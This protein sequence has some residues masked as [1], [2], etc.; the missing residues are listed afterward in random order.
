LPYNL[1]M[2]AV[3]VAVVLLLRRRRG[4][5]DW[6]VA[7]GGAGAAACGLGLVLGVVFENPFGVLRLW[8]YGI[9]FHGTLLLLATA[10]LCRRRPWLAAG[11]ALAAAGLVAVAADA[12][13]VE[14][15]RLEISHRR[16]ASRKIHKP[17][18]IVVVADLQTDC[19]GPFERNVLRQVVDEKPDVI[20]F[21]G[22]Y[23]ESSWEEQAALRRQLRELLLDLKSAAPSAVRMFAVRGNCD[24]DDWD[25]I[26]E[27]TGI[28]VVEARRGFDL[29]DIRLTCLGM[30]ESSCASLALA[31]PSP[32]RFHLVLGHKPDFAL[33]RIEADLLVAGHTHGGQVQLPGVGPLLTLSR[34]PRR[35]A[36]GL[37]E[38]PGGGKLLVS[39]GLGMERGYAPRMRFLCRPELVVV[40]LTPEEG[41]TE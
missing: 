12:F 40:D 5:V 35:W 25:E 3:D 6:C 17:V 41:S 20:L 4:A 1:L 10:I 30:G 9:F 34:V 36:S 27:G 33:G 26:F 11:A 13:L 8:S 14:P 31:N 21:A 37:T 38:L 39:R 18:R 16:I 23:I 32:D 22:D 2:L 24:P 28:A 7:M 15:H 19:V 29:G